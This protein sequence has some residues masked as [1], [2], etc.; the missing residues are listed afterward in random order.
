MNCTENKSNKRN[1]I[2]IAKAIGIILMVAGHIFITNETQPLH[3]FIYS[4]HMPLFF[5]LSG[6]C[7]SKKHLSSFKPYIRKKIHSLY[8]PY[9]IWHSFFAILHNFLF[10]IGIYNTTDLW[11][12]EGIYTCE[13]FFLNLYN[14]AI[15][16]DGKEIL[17]G[18][19]W[20]VR[21]LFF[22]CIFSWITIKLINKKKVRQK[23][24]FFF[25]SFL[26]IVSPL[27]LYMN[28]NR[29]P[30]LHMNNWIYW[31]FTMYLFGYF[32]RNWEKPIPWYAV[33]ISFLYILAICLKSPVTHPD[34]RSI[35]IYTSTSILGFF[36]IF[37]IAHYLVKMR[38]SRALVYIGNHT[39]PIL[40]LHFIVFRT[41]TYF[42][43][44]LSN[45]NTIILSYHPLPEDYVSYFWWIYLIL[46]IL[47]P[48]LVYDLVVRI[49]I[50]HK[51][52]SYF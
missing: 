7:F 17:V 34:Y 48:I 42:I 45:G 27:I 9:V 24:H 47:I 11:G 43:V 37:G 12:C 6:F 35:Y 21:T 13:R 22:V 14:I 15:H 4:F 26:I 39:M 20:F 33:L 46:G 30:F 38:I 36:M 44:M 50:V 2:S 31:G 3:D 1:D 29:I 19:L 18:Q 49:P 23:T 40:I 32:F 10:H 8:F 52:L 16:L 51:I 5:I 41:I 28:L 25:I